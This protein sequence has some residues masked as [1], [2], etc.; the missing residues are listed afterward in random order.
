MECMVTKERGRTSDWETTKSP[1]LLQSPN[2]TDSLVL[3][4]DDWVEDETVLETLNLLNHLGLLLWGAVVVDDTET[5]LESNGDGHLVLGD[6]VHRRGDKWSLEGDALGDW[7]LEGDARGWKVDGAWKDQEVVV[8]ETTV[9]VGV[10][11][12][13]DGESIRAVLGVVLLQDLQGSGGIEGPLALC[14]AQA[15]LGIH[16][17]ERHTD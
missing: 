2:L 1:L 12:L 5:S 7:G 6:S 14:E 16:V 3:A 17:G 11:E 4:E 9:L 8:G 13:M 15:G 10:E